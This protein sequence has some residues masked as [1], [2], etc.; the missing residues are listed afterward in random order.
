VRKPEKFACEEGLQPL[1]ILSGK[2]WLLVRDWLLRE[3]HGSGCTEF[4]ATEQKMMLAE[5][6]A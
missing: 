4:G 5:M 2:Y 6:E 3:V 1:K